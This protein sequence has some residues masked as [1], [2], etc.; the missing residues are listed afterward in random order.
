MPDD[1]YEQR[2][3]R[4]CPS[5]L[6]AHATPPREW[7]LLQ[8]DCVVGVGGCGLDRFSYGVLRA[9][10]LRVMIPILLSWLLLACAT[11]A[12][13][14]FDLTI[15]HINDL[16]S[17]FDPTD[18]Y[19]AR[20]K[21]G[22]EVR[23]VGGAARQLHLCL[24][25]HEFDD[26]PSGL[27]PFV[28]R[29]KGSV[30]VL[31][32]N[33]NFS[34]EPAIESSVNKSTVLTVQGHR[35][36]IIG[37]IT[38]DTPALSSPGNVTFSDDIAAIEMEAEML[39]KQGVAIIIALTHVGYERDMEIAA[40]VPAV[41]VVVGGHSHS[42]LYTGEDHPKEDKPKG[43]Y[44][45]VVT[46][47][48]GTK[49]LVV[50]AHC[51]GKYLGFLNVSFNAAGNIVTW[52]GNPILLEHSIPEDEDML[53]V[54]GKYRE[55]VTAATRAPVG[56]SRVLLNAD[57]GACRR[58]E[59]NI[60]NLLAD[61]FFENYLDMETSSKHVWSVANGVLLNGGS[62]RT[63]IGRS[64]Q[65]NME[66]VMIALPFGNKLALVNLTGAQLYR[67]FEHGVENYHPLEPSGS[68]PQVS[69]FRVH[70]DVSRPKM[71]RV[72]SLKTL[73]T[74]CIVPALEV[75]DV[76][77][78]YTIVTIEYI[79]KGGDGYDFSDADILEYGDK[80]IDAFVEYFR[81]LSPVAPTIED[82]IVFVNTP[83]AQTKG[84][85]ADG[86]SCDIH[87]ALIVALFSLLVT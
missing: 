31:A 1:R 5:L 78:H 74:H 21:P 37:A 8:A 24:G 68:F 29:L 82:R 51:Y 13:Q 87:V 39:Q 11:A 20:C 16:H 7:A 4:K 15:L 63:S 59:C 60:G 44:P 84:N 45:T 38:V 71:E 27:Q 83:Q 46:R 34:A 12:A 47:A 18:P 80:D 6:G 57:D 36:G 58:A 53:R 10:S 28:S 67:L 66:D 26:G 49:G 72:V 2:E 48:D 56:A 86:T 79:A 23:C 30:P 17:H 64:D 70:Y 32:C 40:K 61:S 22:T 55:Y 69:G 3:K 52:S 77:E 75:V 85:A 76:N 43:P 35:I 14:P 41:D 33:A 50:Q 73:C 81:K 42:F 62:I 65:I 9:Q 19:G 25:N 54:L